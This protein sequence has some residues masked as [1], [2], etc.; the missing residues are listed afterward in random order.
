VYE[1]SRAVLQ[2]SLASAGRMSSSKAQTSLPVSNAFIESTKTA[3]HRDQPR[4]QQQ[5]LD[6]HHCSLKFSS[7]AEL[8]YHLEELAANGLTQPAVEESL[9]SHHHR[10]KRKQKQPKPLVQTLS[11]NGDCE[12]DETGAVSGNARNMKLQKQETIVDDQTSNGNSADQSEVHSGHRETAGEIK[13]EP[14][15]SIMNRSGKSRERYRLEQGLREQSVD[16]GA[17][18]KQSVANKENSEANSA[19]WLD[20]EPS[21][22]PNGDNSNAEINSK[23]DSVRCSSVENVV[24]VPAL[25]EGAEDVLLSNNNNDASGGGKNS[26][27][28]SSMWMESPGFAAVIGG[29][30]RCVVCGLEC[31]DFADLETHC[32]TEHSRSPCM[33]CTKTFA[34]KANRDRHVCLHTGDRPY[35]CPECGE[36]FSRGDKLKMHRVRMHGVLY[37]LYG[38]RGGGAHRGNRSSTSPMSLTC[39]G[40]LSNADVSGGNYDV[41][42]SSGTRARDFQSPMV[43][44]DVVRNGSSENWR[45]A[46]TDWMDGR[47]HLDPIRPWNMV[48]SALLS[49]FPKIEVVTDDEAR[50]SVA[51]GP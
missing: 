2:N 6:C 47:P 48:S 28:G 14:I 18:H 46:V 17:A 21:T 8:A 31:S 10:D 29:P 23:D 38:P 22:T 27:S 36:R 49:H 15:R 16:I 4:Q 24:A 44:S 13:M 40:D 20:G 39:T 30:Q 37:P 11:E 42:C 26:G 43:G 41:D 19:D 12:D 45:S 34:Q 50:G 3:L 33:F 35:G 51:N 25:P 9:A 7:Y 1:L 32:I 5:H